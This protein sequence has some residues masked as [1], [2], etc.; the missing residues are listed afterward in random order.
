MP[1]YEV[2]I[3]Q[4]YRR[5]YVGEERCVVFV[6]APDADKA[7]EAAER[8]ADSEIEDDDG[9]EITDYDWESG[10]D[11]CVDGEPCGVREIDVS[12]PVSVDDEATV[13]WKPKA[14]G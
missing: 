5:V 2:T 8:F 10:K 12:G 4:P 7:R 3:T 13:T 11:E 1:V 14:E 9:C 6:E